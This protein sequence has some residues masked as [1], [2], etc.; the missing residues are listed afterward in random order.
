MIRF[1]QLFSSIIGIN[2]RMAKVVKMTT[3]IAFMY[4]HYKIYF[5][6]SLSST[7]LK[8]FSLVHSAANGPNGQDHTYMES[9]MVNSC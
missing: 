3:M 5:C 4:H 8:P 6:F 1:T 7:S 9:L 2:T